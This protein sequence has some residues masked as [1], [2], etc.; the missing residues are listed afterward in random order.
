MT[1]PNPNSDSNEDRVSTTRLLSG[2]EFRAI[3]DRWVAAAADRINHVGVADPDVQWAL[4]GIKRRG[5]VLARRL[6][7][8]L[9]ESNR[10]VSKQELLYGQVD[11]SLYRDDYH[12]HGS[13]PPLKEPGGAS[14]VKVLGT[15]ISWSVD[16]VGILLVD[17]VLFTGRTV[18]AAMNV[19]LDYGRPR[20]ILL[21]V[22][23]DRGHRELPI[24]A[25]VVGKEI[26]TPRE[27]QVLVQLE[28]MEGV[29][30][31]DLIQR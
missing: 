18:R 3:Y 8:S 13:R 19:I 9:A 12:V 29:D 14:Q 5:A 20:T 24:M 31:V 6:W 30:C 10:L 17:D 27:G 4:V 21:G 7:K 26:S 15:E 23:I 11:I 2:E 22:Y 28:E 16:G 1:V 25:D